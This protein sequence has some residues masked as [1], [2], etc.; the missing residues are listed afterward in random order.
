MPKKSKKSK[1]RKGSG[2][3]YRPKTCNFSGCDTVFDPA[4][5][6][7]KYCCDEHQVAGEAEKAKARREAWKE[8]Q[9]VTPSPTS[10]KSQ[11]KKRKGNGKKGPEQAPQI[12]AAKKLKRA[13]KVAREQGLASE[14][15]RP[16]VSVPA[17]VKPA[18]KTKTQQQR[19]QKK[20][21]SKITV[22]QEDDESPR[23]P[24]SSG[25]GLEVELAPQEE[26]PEDEA[27]P[28][29]ETTQMGPFQSGHRSV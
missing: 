5:P 22:V 17:L 12:A 18:A 20:K 8:S 14:E 7:N 26:N 9:A 24:Q 28:Q 1:K 19:R 2:S 3:V 27:T 23:T 16:V 21:R 10:Q 15:S 6:A 25:E 29:Q 4:T 11:P 13:A